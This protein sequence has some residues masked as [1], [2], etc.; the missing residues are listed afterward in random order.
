MPFDPRQRHDALTQ[1]RQL[2]AQAA[3]GALQPQVGRG[4]PLVRPIRAPGVAPWHR[5]GLLALEHGGQLRLAAARDIIPNLAL[6]AQVAWL[7]E[8]A[9]LQAG[10]QV[11]LRDPV[12]A[13]GVRV[14][15]ALAV[16]HVLRVAAGILELI[17]H[18]GFL[19]LLHHA[20]RVEESER[21]V[22]LR[23]SRQVEAGHRQVKAPLRQSHIIE[24]LRR[25]H[26]YLQ[27]VRIGQAHIFA[28]KDQHAPEDE[29]RVLA[30]IDH[31]RHPVERSVRV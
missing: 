13:V 7:V 20:Q 22:A 15:V 14:E 5:C 9:A 27:G 17:R 6:I 12:I 29:A 30:S 21:A 16:P 10:R 2:L 8:D 28:G 31:L 3:Q 23:R 4:R 1:P 25:G 11:L 19:L 26:H 24:R 18:L